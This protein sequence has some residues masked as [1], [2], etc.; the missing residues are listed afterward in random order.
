MRLLMCAGEPSG[1]IR[2]GELLRALSA[3]TTVE[4]FG[5]GGDAMAAEGMETVL[6][7]RD[8]S[9]MG[10]T[11]VFRSLPRVI[12]AEREL[13][14]LVISRKP[15]ALLLVD[16]PG[17]NMRFGA[18]ARA[19]GIPVV[20]YIAPQTWAWGA[21][22]TRKLLKSC[23]L[24]L[25]ILPFEEDFFRHSG[26]N[27]LYTGHPLADQ[28]PLPLPEPSGPAR[29]ALLPGSRAQEVT[30]LLP[31]ML[32]AFRIL[33]AGG[34]VSGA[35]VAVSDSVDKSAYPEPGNGLELAEGT[36]AALRNA[37]AAL[38][39]SGTATLETAMYGVPQ[40]ICYKTGRVNYLLAR[41]LV[42]GVGRIGLA[43]LVAGS[44]IAPELLQD[45][46]RADIMAQEVSKALRD[47]SRRSATD[48]V[49]LRLGPPG[50]AGR[51]AEAV[52]RFLEAG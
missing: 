15:D 16:Y 13:R 24:L 45:R 41:L 39:C 48:A 31:E 10:F 50:G 42:R 1:D 5:M 6:N 38:V 23:G 49:R 2:G 17:F 47:P 27:T 14:R 8:L 21:W 22:R 9:V 40:V 25:V 3:G 4:A 44:D 52:I 26:I 28:V 19:R 11:E 34:E 12:A 43:N 35:S 37:S 30:R 29:I 51:A 46:A 7:I 32:E 33:H 36:A 18:W 20:Q